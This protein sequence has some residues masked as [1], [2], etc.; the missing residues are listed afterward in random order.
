MDKEICDSNIARFELLYRLIPVSRV[1]ALLLEPNRQDSLE[2]FDQT[3]VDHN[4]RIGKCV[5]T[6]RCAMVPTTR[7]LDRFLLKR[8]GG[9]LSSIPDPTLEK[10][11]NNTA[12]EPF[13]G[14]PP[15]DEQL[16]TYSST[17]HDK[18]DL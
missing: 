12:A 11:I 8:L 6:S 5:G 16:L 2:S 3:R 4:K 17:I 1:A 15:K 10:L 9:S 13:Y 7:F 18:L 14:R